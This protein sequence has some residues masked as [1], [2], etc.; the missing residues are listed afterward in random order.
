[1]V[2]VFIYQ[3]VGQFLW[4]FTKLLK[5]FQLFGHEDFDLNADAK[6]HISTAGYEPTTQKSEGKTQA[7]HSRSVH[8]WANRPAAG[9]D[10]RRRRVEPSRRCS[11]FSRLRLRCVIVYL[12]SRQRFRH[13]KRHR[14]R[15][16]RNSEA[17]DVWTVEWG[18]AGLFIWQL[19]SPDSV[20][21]KHLGLEQLM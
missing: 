18:G 17:L 6:K 13:A 10:H 3:I 12:N 8:D 5:S 1:M 19:P 20:A 2:L 16:T 7:H 9:P 14:Y 11:F 4:S 15:R 21:D